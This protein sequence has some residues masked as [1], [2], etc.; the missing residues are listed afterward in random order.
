M[1]I[2]NWGES[3]KSLK[4]CYCFI[5][6]VCIHCFLHVEEDWSELVP[7]TERLDTSAH[8]AKGLLA[9]K[10]KRQPPSRTKLKEGLAMA[11]S[12]SQVCCELL[13]Y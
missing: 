5:Y 8:R 9:Q 4:L 11:L 12:Q 2:V 13:I 1:H 10:A 6:S 3:C 7:E